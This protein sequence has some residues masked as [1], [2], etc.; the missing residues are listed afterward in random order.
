MSEAAG[1]YRIGIVGA[2][3]ISDLHFEGIRRHPDRARV[4]AMCDPDA[5]GLRDRAR[6]FG[7]SETYPGVKE[8]IADT[9][10]DAVIV[11]TPT[12]VRGEVLMPMIEKGIPVL[13]EKPFAETF[14]EAATIEAAARKAGVKVAVNQNFRRHFTFSLAKELKQTGITVNA[15]C[16]GII[17]TQMWYGPN[18]LAE[19]W[20]NPGETME[21]SWKRHQEILI[22][23]GEAQTPEDMGDL[24]VY[25]ATAE[26]VTAQAI[27]VDGGFTSH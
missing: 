3:N 5:T 1:P 19:K 2:G 17:G 27:N 16:P 9:R 10:L 12:H 8:M 20:K 22:P 21:E 15:I 18:G 11:C 24:A 23:Q 14:R 13:C 4:V 26:H 25:L 7:V 6:K